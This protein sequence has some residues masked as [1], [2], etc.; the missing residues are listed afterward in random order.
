MHASKPR[1]DFLDVAKAIGILCVIALHSF[2]RSARELAIPGSPEQWA[3]ILANRLFAFAVPM[4]LCISAFLW[5]RSQRS[6]ERLFEGYR[7]RIL[8]ILHPYLVW[9]L[10]FMVWSI[11]V[12]KASPAGFRSFHTWWNDLLW[13]KAF[14]HLYFLSILVQAALLFPLMYLLIKRLNF[15]AVCAVAFTLQAV[16]F[17]SQTHWQYLVFPGSSVL[18][19]IT[20]LLPAAWLGYRWPISNPSLK[21]LAIGSFVVT[22]LSVLPYLWLQILDLDKIYRFS[23]LSNPIQQVFVFG[24]SF[25]L[26]SFLALKPATAKPWMVWLGAVS[27]Q[28]YLL[29]PMLMRLTSGPHILGLMKQIPGGSMVVYVLILAFTVV[30]VWVLNKLKLERILFGRSSPPLPKRPDQTSERRTG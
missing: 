9:T 18:W 13:G 12:E 7:R 23:G 21:K 10:I 2:G 26:I 17:W 5:A 22:V 30:A 3:L 1:L 15:F 25:W 19:Y 20:S 11:A 29:H 6:K 4:F 16:V 27:L 14:F 8:A 28:F 24:T